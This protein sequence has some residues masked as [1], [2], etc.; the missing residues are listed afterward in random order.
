MGTTCEELIVRQ[1]V[2]LADEHSMKERLDSGGT[3][4]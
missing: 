3:A 4:R 2:I 1:E